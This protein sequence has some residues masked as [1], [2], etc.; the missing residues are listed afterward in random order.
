MDLGTCPGGRTTNNFY[1]V[2]VV[3]DMFAL[4]GSTQQASGGVLQKS[5]SGF[6]SFGQTSS[7]QR[8]D[9]HCRQRFPSPAR[10]MT[11]S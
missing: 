1:P 6:Q 10:P 3:P 8:R 4:N 9:D 11:I 5:Q 2:C 7:G